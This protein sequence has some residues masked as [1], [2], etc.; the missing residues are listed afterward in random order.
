M[1]SI[2]IIVDAVQNN[3]LSIALITALNKSSENISVYYKN[4]GYNNFIAPRFSVSFLKDCY[5]FDGALVATSLETAKILQ[6]TFVENKYLYL[7]NLEWMKSRLSFRELSDIY[8]DDSIKLI[9]RSEE[10]AKKVESIWKKPIG[11]VKDF[12]QIEKLL[13]A[14]T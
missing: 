12:V 14:S 7:W 2:G 11:V 4:V 10:H 9:C 13:N 3:D 6:K 1:K 5:V 8:L